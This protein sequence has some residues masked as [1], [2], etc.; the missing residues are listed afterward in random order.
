MPLRNTPIRRK[1]MAAFLL[2]GGAVLLLTCAAFLAYE[3]VTLRKGMVD[4]YAT[5]SQILAANSTAALA[6]QNQDDATGVLAALQSDTHVVAACL[7]DDKGKLFAKYPAGTPDGI[8]P[9]GPG[10]SGYRGGKLET[11]TPVVQGD[12]FLGTVYI[13][14]DLAAL[15]ERYHAYA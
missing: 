2:T 1:L 5:R 3:I 9:A 15:T 10:S 14:S 11:F 4:A 6:F 7:Y 12:R 13:Q 8:F